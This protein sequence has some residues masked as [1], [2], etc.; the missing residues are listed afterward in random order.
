[1]L[2]YL[3]IRNLALIEDLQLEFAPGLNALTG[4]TGAGK[5]F[6]LKALSFL[7]G[8]KLATD[9]VRPGC[10]KALVEA[11]FV[12][13]DED[14]VLRRELAADSGRSRLFLNDALAS[15][16]SVRALRPGLLLH[17][18]QHGQQRLLQPGYQARI[19][20]GFLDSPGLV[21]DRDRLLKELRELSQRVEE[22]E[23]R[24]RS[25]LDKREYL[26]FQQEE[27]RRVEPQP[28]EEAELEE[29]KKRLRDAAEASAAIDAGLTILAG[30]AP[31]LPDILRELE[32]ALH[33]L[34]QAEP[35]F[36]EP[37]ARVEAMRHD[38][39]DIESMLR[40]APAAEPPEREIE[41]IEARLFELSRLK[42]KL[43]RSLAEIVDLG[44][45]I[46]DNLNFLDSCELERKRLAKERSAKARELAQALANLNDARRGA[47]ERF[48]AAMEQELKGLGF[49]EH[50][51]V[52][53]GFAAVELHPAVEGVSLVED[54]ASFLW[55]PNPGQPEQPLDKI[56]SGGELSRF[57]LAL[58]GLTA[59][60]S[61]ESPTL[62]FDEVDAGV[63]GLTL[64]SVGERIS[65][66]AE[67]R[68]VILIT[69]WPQL[70]S[71]AQRHFQVRK[72]V[73]DGQTFTLLTRLDEDRRFEELAR[74]AGGGAQGRAMASELTAEER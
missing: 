9:M 56:A 58:T 20:D 40:R 8:D 72:E 27:I 57:L 68:Q 55:R 74:M 50:V 37:R 33:D 44:R 60:Q 65:T 10:D 34:A 14:M 53:C 61:D 64:V 31:N 19:L 2:E 71:L 38:L 24:S 67:M 51:R 69:H 48:S 62:I 54:R 17:A 22:L 45:E 42:R 46:E 25:L 21:A 13:G 52:R 28:G 30:P 32:S 7:T 4:E 70:A 39:G 66:L 35:G 73:R 47:A 23:Q 43:K 5:S 16:D 3:R 15:Q 11:L 49:S 59:Q 1:M 6:I 26:E 63:G 12:V 29:R 18:S 41:A 36:A